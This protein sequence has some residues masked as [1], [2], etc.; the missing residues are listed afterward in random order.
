MLRFISIPYFNYFLFILVLLSVTFSFYLEYIY[1]IIPCRLC[2]YQRYLWITLLFFCFLNLN[3]HYKN[4]K[5]I[6][7]IN[8][9]ILV[10]IVILSFYHS[11]VELGI[12]NNILSCELKEK[13]IPNSIKELDAIIRNTANNNC[14]FPKFFIFNLSLSNLSLILSSILLLLSLKVFKNN[15]FKKDEC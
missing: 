4:K 11:G 2:L 7:I 14:A 10:F 12:Y 15:I 5:I 13:I 9:I 8:I 6:F 1:D 3:S